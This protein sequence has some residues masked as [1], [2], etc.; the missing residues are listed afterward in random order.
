MKGA[1]IMR[2]VTILLCLLG[3]LLMPPAAYTQPAA[4]TLTVGCAAEGYT[5]QVP[6]GWQIRNNC[7]AKT[8]VVFGHITLKI[9]VERH[10]WWSDARSRSSISKDITRPDQHRTMRMQVSF[11]H[12]TIGGRSFLS[13]SGGY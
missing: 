6:A 8:T 4:R 2:T 12:V 9:A 10:S 5:M 13:G 7:T 3:A 11:L 1:H